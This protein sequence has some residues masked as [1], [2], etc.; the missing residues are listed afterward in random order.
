MVI[1]VKSKINA[2]FQEF[3]ENLIWYIAFLVLYVFLVSMLVIIGFYSESNVLDYVAVFLGGAGFIGLQVLFE[4]PSKTVSGFLKDRSDLIISLRDILIVMVLL[5]GGLKIYG[6]YFFQNHE[7]TIRCEGAVTCGS[8]D[9]RSPEPIADIQ[10]RILVNGAVLHQSITTSEGVLAEK[11]FSIP[12]KDQD[13]YILVELS[14]EQGVLAS[15]PRI[16]SSTSGILKVDHIFETSECEGSV[17]NGE[18]LS[19]VDK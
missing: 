5:V 7:M 14:N 4:E 1:N 13:D 10:I 18:N 3:R 6:G 9:D 12:R 15:N 11:E 19:G 8:K 17:S 16:L 2:K